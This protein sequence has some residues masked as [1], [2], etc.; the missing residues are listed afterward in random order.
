MDVF[1]LSTKKA[2]RYDP[3]YGIENLPRV[4][5]GFQYPDEVPFVETSMNRQDSATYET[6]LMVFLAAGQGMMMLKDGTKA[7]EIRRILQASLREQKL[8][9]EGDKFD[10]MFPTKT[11]L[12]EIPQNCRVAGIEVG[13]R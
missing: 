8:Q 4:V 3:R 13:F 7:D 6:L 10:C 1:R 2:F 9:V 5:E 11:S 12:N